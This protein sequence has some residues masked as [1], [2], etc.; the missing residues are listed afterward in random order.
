LCLVLHWGF[1]WH[2]IHTEFSYSHLVQKLKRRT[3]TCRAMI[4]YFS[5]FL[6]ALKERKQDE[7]QHKIIWFGGSMMNVTTYEY[8]LPYILS[9]IIDSQH[10]AS[11][12]SPV[13]T[14]TIRVDLD[15]VWVRVAE[16]L[17]SHTR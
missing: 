15:R 9:C 7:Y 10:F 5:F 1:Y 17:G 14:V 6:L 13:Q 12:V 4:S 8:Y 16:R 11:C 2:D 3:R